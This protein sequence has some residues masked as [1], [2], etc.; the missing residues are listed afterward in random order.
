[1]TCQ[2]CGSEIEGG[3]K[4]RA[5]IEA[6]F[7]LKCR[8]E[9]RR[10]KLKYDWLPQPI[11]TCELTTTAGF[12]SAGASSRNWSGKPAFRSGTS[13]GKRNASA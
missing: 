4:D 9:R 2:E 1:M 6:K 8:A 10:A 13:N 12:V 7:C 3:R 11:P 5:L